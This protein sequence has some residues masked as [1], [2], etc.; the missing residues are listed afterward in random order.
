MTLLVGA[1]LYQP[2]PGRLRLVN[3]TQV[4]V[5]NKNDPRH[6]ALNL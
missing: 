3:W 5:F 6:R 1:L 2:H 4:A